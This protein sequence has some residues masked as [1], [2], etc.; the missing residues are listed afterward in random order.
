MEAVAKLHR[1]EAE[2]IRLHSELNRNKHEQAVFTD[3][4]TASQLRRQVGIRV[5][6]CA[7]THLTVLSCGMIRNHPLQV[8]SDELE[9]SE[10][11]IAQWALA[12]RHQREA[13]ELQ[14]AGGWSQ[15]S[16]CPPHHTTG[17]FTVH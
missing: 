15:T 3:N 5:R 12:R 11:W 2:I 9:H 4:Q 7:T 6:I 14:A 1:A 17:L 10:V 13:E 8:L 16:L